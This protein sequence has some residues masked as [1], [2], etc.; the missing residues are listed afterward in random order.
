MLGITLLLKWKERAVFSSPHYKPL[1][2]LQWF[3]IFVP[4][5]LTRSLFFK[6]ETNHLKMSSHQVLLV[7]LHGHFLIVSQAPNH[8]I[9]PMGSLTAS[10][11]LHR[12][13]EACER[14]TLSRIWGGFWSSWT[15]RRERDCAA[16]Y[17]IRQHTV[18]W[19]GYRD[20]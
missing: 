13:W 3:S 1:F 7:E 20:T 4:P 5:L 10:L 2:N 19:S 14:C 11:Q 12:S 8:L 9:I 15:P 17:P 6:F 18:W 16:R